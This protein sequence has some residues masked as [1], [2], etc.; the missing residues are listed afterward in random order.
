[1]QMFAAGA[2]TGDAEF[3]LASTEQTAERVDVTATAI[4]L[5]FALDVYMDAEAFGV[6]VTRRQG[7]ANQQ[8]TP[9]ERARL[10]DV[11]CHAQIYQAKCHI[12]EKVFQV[13]L[14]PSDAR[15]AKP[16]LMWLTIRRG[17]DAY[18]ISLSDF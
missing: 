12:E 11:L 14:V 15:D 10:L 18:F 2:P 17:T 6:A 16:R 1:M 4:S 3:A 8:L 5:H 13:W 7:A 9:D